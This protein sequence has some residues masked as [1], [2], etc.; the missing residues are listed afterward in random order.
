MANFENNLYCDIDS[1]LQEFVSGKDL[2]AAIFDETGTNLIAISGQQTLVINREAEAVEINT[3]DSGGWKDAVQGLKFW[4]TE[5]DGAYAQNAESRK[6]LDDAFNTGKP[7]CI[8]IINQALKKAIL[9]GMAIVVK[10]TLEAPYDDGAIYSID[11]KGKGKLVD[12]TDAAYS[13]ATQ[14]PGEAGVVGA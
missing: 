6:L 11:L 14:M 3:K 2:I 7:L 13:E 9:G 1:A 5:I 12:L 10:N 4:N 8:K